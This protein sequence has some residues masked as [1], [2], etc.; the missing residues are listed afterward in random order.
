[1]LFLASILICITL[2]DLD[3]ST[4][5]NGFIVAGIIGAFVF[6][7]VPPIMADSSMLDLLFVGGRTL[8]C[9]LSVSLPLLILSL[10]MDRVLRRDSLGGGDIKLFFMIGLYF[11]WQVD[12]LTLIVSCVLGIVFSVLWFKGRLTTGRAFPFGPAIAVATWI[13]MLVGP[14]AVTWYLGLF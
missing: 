2:T 13:S 7:A 8:L 5:P 11:S 3:D 14:V 4:I 10:I 12:L 1:M 9:G 6:A